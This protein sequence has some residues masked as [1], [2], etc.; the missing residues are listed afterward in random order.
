MKKL[1]KLC[2]YGT[3]SSMNSKLPYPDV[4]FTANQEWLGQCTICHS[5]HRITVTGENF[6]HQLTVMGEASRVILL[7]G[8]NS[9]KSLRSLLWPK[10]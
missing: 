4:G 10:N 7:V 1:M 9:K 3:V 6:V 8:E 5:V 2:L